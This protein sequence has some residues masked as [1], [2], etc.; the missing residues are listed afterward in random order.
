MNNI[1]HHGLFR[2]ACVVVPLF[3]ACVA[4]KN[5]TP[6]QS[7]NALGTLSKKTVRV[8]LIGL[9]D[10]HGNIE[11]KEVVLGT[12]KS[13]VTL[14]GMALMSAYLKAARSEN[15]QS[16]LV[17][18]AGDAYQGTLLSNQFFGQPIVAAYNALKIDAS[19]FGNHE[20]DWGAGAPSARPGEKRHPQA[21]LLSILSAAKFPY[22][23]ASVRKENNE[24]TG[25][26][27]VEAGRIFT[28][29][30]VKV[31]V[32]GA[33]TESTP[34]SSDL[35]SIRGLKFL[36]LKDSV[37]EHAKKLREQG[38]QIIVLL[39]HAGGYCDMQKA[40]E[41]GDSACKSPL[42]DEVTTF[43][44][45]VPKGT[46]DAILAGHMHLPQAHFIKGVPVVQTTGYGNSF[47]RI[48]I[49]V[50]PNALPFD[51]VE[52]RITKIAI[53]KPTYFCKNHFKNYASCSP[54]EEKF[55]G[56]YPAV[57]GS[58]TPAKYKGIEIVPDAQF[59]SL[60][61]EFTLKIQK[62]QEKFIVKLPE[63][64]PQDRTKESSMA[65]CFADLAKNAIG[66]EAKLSLDAAVIH[67][68]GIRAG[69]PKGD[70]NY[71]MIYAVQ[72]FEGGFAVLDLSGEELQKFGM[73]LSESS[74]S[75]PVVSEGWKT[76]IAAKAQYPR[77]RGFLDS[78]GNPLSPSKRYKILTL[79]FNV[80]VGGIHDAL[81]S[82]PRQEGR[83]RFFTK[84]ARDVVADEFA[85]SAQK[86][87][88]SC[89]GEAPNRTLL[90]EN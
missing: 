28:L 39:T 61:Q 27:N 77:H 32:V 88:P 85:R 84:L 21:A 62:Q 2:L 18:D 81:F 75:I 13:K 37:P 23:S 79:D 90:V 22:L 41:A 70:V 34:N 10:L 72:P 1:F 17:L 51:T 58:P 50:V 52:K 64:L 59:D 30:G 47:S 4:G 76:R 33:T 89:K 12:E 69:L 49:D 87:P 74:K 83:I 43:L 3:S 38:A 71:G 16:T 57:F 78:S 29:N 9:N 24:G 46:V 73:Q 42:K 11:S 63:P 66:R 6:D 48:D 14:G 31:G 44:E 7:K 26:P 15:P 35:E 25:F 68:G 54:D 20:F 60:L 36:A 56:T 19:T 53:D 8:S 82:K 40:A 86:L 55:G 67:S 45:A 5:E 80:K 65:N